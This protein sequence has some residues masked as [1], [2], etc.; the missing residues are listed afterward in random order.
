MASARFSNESGITWDQA[1]KAARG[2]IE[3]YGTK[4]GLYTASQNPIENYTNAILR[5]T[6]SESNNE[7]IFWRNDVKANWASIS[8]D[9]P[10]G[11]GGNGGLCP[12]QNLVDMYDMADGS[13]PFTQY[14]ETGAPIYNGIN[15]PTIRIES[16][17]D[18]NAPYKNRDPR[19]AASILYHGVKWGNGTINVIKGQ[20]DNPSGNAN[21]TPTGYYVRKYIPESILSVNH[22]GSSYR[23]WI[24]FRYAEI[25][26]NYAE[27]LN[28]DG[29]SREDVL[30]ILQPL[31][32]RAGLTA[33]LVNRTDLQTQDEIRN[34][35]RKERTVELAFED[36]RA[37]DVRRWNVA[38][39]ALARPI[40][41][42]DVTLNGDK[43]I[44]SRKIAQERVFA[45]KMYLYPIPEGEIWKTNIENNPGWE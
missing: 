30:N 33:K 12:S 34:F 28:E 9:T 26:L 35:I 40:Y 10:V 43:T 2:F 25:I 20:R 4:Y 39:K 32:D 24:I 44:Y 45:P 16:N 31:R 15:C 37:W 19:L 29:G 11:E 36:H 3:D 38:E 1:A 22:S 14:D 23:N 5:N 6:Y 17:Y 41:G 27:A 42:I 21:A 8:N 18:D 7:V 13:S